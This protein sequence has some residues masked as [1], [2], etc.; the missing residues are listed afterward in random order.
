MDQQGRV[1]VTDLSNER[2]QV[3]TSAGELL[4]IWTDVTRGR[5][6]RPIKIE[7]GDDDLLYV[8]DVELAQIKVF[9]PAG[10]YVRQ[11]SD[12]LLT[13]VDV[14]VQD[15]YAYVADTGKHQILKFTT[16]GE[17]VATWGDAGSGDGEFSQI[18]GIAL[19]AYGYV[20]VADAGNYR[21]QKFTTGGVWL[22]AFGKVGSGPGQFSNLSGIDVH[23]EVI[24]T[25]EYTPARV[26]RFSLDGAFQGQFGGQGSAQGQFSGPGGMSVGADGY[27]YVADQENHRIQKLTATGEFIAMLTPETVPDMPAMSSPC[28]LAVDREGR[29]YAASSGLEIV[30]IFT[31]RIVS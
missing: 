23:D 28:G 26:Q 14:A 5:F 18:R 19:D 20:Y 10:E 2:I 27:V 6:G 7:H 15:G 22:A 12:R 31:P 29:I 16:S 25:V 24:Y 17:H 30:M 21:I 11:W 8:V 9:T 13:P 3:F 4:D 1:Y